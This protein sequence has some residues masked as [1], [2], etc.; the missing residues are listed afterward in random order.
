MLRMKVFLFYSL[1][2][3]FVSS[4]EQALPDDSPQQQVIE[5]AL[6]SLTYTPKKGKGIEL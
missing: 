1:L 4:E 5:D 3:A 6:P 2:L